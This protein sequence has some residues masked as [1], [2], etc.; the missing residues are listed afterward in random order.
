MPLTPVE[1]LVPAVRSRRT[2]ESAA[3]RDPIN[4]DAMRYQGFQFSYSV[5]QT[6]RRQLKLASSPTPPSQ[7][8]CK[9]STSPSS[10][11]GIPAAVPGLVPVPA[12]WGV[13]LARGP[14]H[15]SS[16]RYG[17]RCPDSYQLAWPLL[18]ACRPVG[19]HRT[20]YVTTTAQVL[21]FTFFFGCRF[22][23]VGVCSLLC[24]LFPVAR[25]RAWEGS[26]LQLTPAASAPAQSLAY[27]TLPDA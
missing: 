3:T 12:H 26:L 13:P 10:I 19:R 23:A 9:S 27:A 21:F 11:F 17:E 7:A 14:T 25:L 6:G 20:T 22:R 16:W 15:A 1:P 4:R 24:N 5:S 8:G 18:S 2:T